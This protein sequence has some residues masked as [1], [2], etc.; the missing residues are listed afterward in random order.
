MKGGDIQRIFEFVS[1]ASEDDRTLLLVWL[2]ACFIPDFPHPIPI[3]YGPQGSGK[4]SFFRRLRRIIDPSTVP[5]LTMPRELNELV[6]QLSHHY[7]P[8]YDNITDLSQWQSD[9]LCRAVTGE[10]FTKRAL[11]TDDE[12]VIYHFQRVLGLNGINVVATKPD[13]LDRAILIGLERIAPDERR[14]EEELDTAFVAALP[15]ILGGV[16]DALVGALKIR[17]SVKLSRLPRM[18]DFALWGCAIAQA[19]GYE[20][21]HFL[22]AYFA[23]ISA[24]NDEVLAGDAVASAVVGFM[25]GRSETWNGTATELLS[26]LEAVALRLKLDVKGRSWPKAPNVLTRRVNAIKS[27]LQDAGI[28]YTKEHSGERRITLLR[29][30]VSENTVQTVQPSTDVGKQGL[31][32]GRYLDDLDGINNDLDDSHNNTVQLQHIDN[33]QVTNIQSLL[34][35]LDGIVPYALGGERDEELI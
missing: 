20:D 15:E 21:G 3:L 13:L 34:D 2:T 7:A 9:T 19:L 1:V 31:T 4:S 35:G 33:E 29:Q 25:N 12:D 30:E 28:F 6:Q 10:G 8:M 32:D 27:N 22:R 14:T 24:Q 11:Y 5:T 18:A 16:F 17:P 23:N 26:E